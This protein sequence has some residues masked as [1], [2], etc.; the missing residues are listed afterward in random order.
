MVAEELTE[1]DAEYIEKLFR[2]G[3]QQ[4]QQEEEQ[5]NSPKQSPKER[6]ID[7]RNAFYFNEILG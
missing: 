1:G 3:A 2:Q 6:L 7:G 5:Q 4:Q